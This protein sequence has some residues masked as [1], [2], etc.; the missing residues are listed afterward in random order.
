MAERL[1]D[2]TRPYDYNQAMMDLGATL[3]T[4]KEPGCA[5][6][7][8]AAE[9]RGKER[10]ERYPEPRMRKRVPVRKR[11]IL[12]RTREG[13]WALVCSGQ[14]FHGGLWHFPQAEE[15]AGELLGR[16][17]QRYSHFTLEAEVLRVE[18]LPAEN[19]ADYFAPEEIEELPL[20]GIDRKILS[21][22]IR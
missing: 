14:R 18:T 7:P 15:A 11:K 10:P 1:F 4:P 20:G 17:I 19:D 6:C 22:Y 5:R 8:L 3:C 13:R 9:C 16:E 12:L 21:V 2:V